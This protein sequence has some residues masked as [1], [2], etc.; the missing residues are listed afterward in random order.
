MKRKCHPSDMHYIGCQEGSSLW[1][2]KISPILYP[3]FRTSNF[4]DP[5]AILYHHIKS[6]DL[7]A[8]RG[9]REN[10]EQ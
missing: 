8:K 9:E 7:S 2:S 6:A 5:L 3:P 1:T 4:G 10:N